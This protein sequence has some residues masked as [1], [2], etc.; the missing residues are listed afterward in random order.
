MLI[1]KTMQTLETSKE[2]FFQRQSYPV[3]Y[4]ES[5]SDFNEQSQIKM[6]SYNFTEFNVENINDSETKI[7]T[8]IF[9]IK[10]KHYHPNATFVSSNFVLDDM[11]LHKDGN[12]LEIG[13][14][15]VVD[16]DVNDT[17]VPHERFYSDASHLG[18]M[19][20]PEHGKEGKSKM[21][22]CGVYGGG[23]GYEKN[24]YSDQTFY[25]VVTFGHLA[26]S[27]FNKEPG[28]KIKTIDYLTISYVD[29]DKYM[30]LN[31]EEYPD[32]ADGKF[33]PVSS[34]NFR[35]LIV[36]NQINLWGGHLIGISEN[37]DI[38]IWNITQK[39][40]GSAGE[41]GTFLNFYAKI[42]DPVNKRDFQYI[43][44]IGFHDNHILIGMDGLGIKI[45]SVDGSTGTTS[46]T[47]QNSVP[48]GDFQTGDPNNQS[49][50]NPSDLDENPDQIENGGR[51]LQAFNTFVLQANGAL[52]GSYERDSA[53]SEQLKKLS[54]VGYYKFN[55]QDMIVNY[56]TFYIIQKGVGLRI[57]NAFSFTISAPILNNPNLKNLEYLE[58]S[59][60]STNLYFIGISA[61]NNPPSS[62][63]FFYEIIANYEFSPTM[64]RV[65][66]SSKTRRFDN[67]V[68]NLR[69]FSVLFD[70]TNN[71]LL[72]LIRGSPNIINIPS[73]IIPINPTLKIDLNSGYNPVHLMFD[74]YTLEP[75]YLV[76]DDND[77]FSITKVHIRP[78]DL[79]CN[80]KD[81]GQYDINLT[82]VNAC[83]DFNG[84][85]DYNY[86]LYTSQT[87]FIIDR[88]A[89]GF[90][91][92]LVILLLILVGVLIFVALYKFKIICK[93]KKNQD[94]RYVEPNSQV[95]DKSTKG[96]AINM[97]EIEIN[98]QH[99]Q[100]EDEKV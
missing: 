68:T 64:N 8:Q 24:T 95:P 25:D 62:P 57:M 13:R 34:I 85:K 78:Y 19:D 96:G 29:L 88:K 40:D 91:A 75:T 23:I 12:L 72:F 38:Y 99:E 3:V 86:C 44:K 20:A 83:S 14:D 46:N 45:Y 49:G 52:S 98:V 56:N 70:K 67:F 94:Q 16:L 50:T 87:V 59:L 36:S 17:I 61:W 30:E 7:D 63:E 66:A 5:P 69:S 76:N 47:Q 1:Q 27:I 60:Y 93:D 9:K 74:Q 58:M 6:K 18:D 35:N 31:K 82:N 42:E 39:R 15:Y 100:L 28:I 51:N 48:K 73:F 2:F 89:S 4:L 37:Y 97:G 32:L 41:I 53:T 79:T 26:F 21:H 84:D 11:T 81:D 80:F 65:W 33:Y 77:Y 22:I 92:L 54:L 55:Y 10:E 71:E 90:I 43:N